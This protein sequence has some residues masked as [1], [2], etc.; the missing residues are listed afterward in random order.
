MRKVVLRMNENFKYSIIKKLVDSNGNK[1]RATLQL[2]CSIRTINRLIIKYKSQGKAGFVHKSRGR[3]PPTS[4]SEQTKR[5][6]IDLYRI[7][8]Y[9]S[10]FTHFCELLKKHE[11]IS[12]SSSTLSSV[13]SSI[14][15]RPSMPIIMSLFR[16]LPLMASLPGSLPTNVPYSNIKEKTYPV[17]KR[18]RLLSS[19]MPVIN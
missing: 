18:I 17:T 19:L 10:N 12:V 5:L 16:S 15:R 13:L 7:K 14:S 4:F 6:V 11:G 2:N 1:K 8:Y 9:D 3:K